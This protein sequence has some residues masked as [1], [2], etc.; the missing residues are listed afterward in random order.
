[1][2][3]RS[4]WN[5]GRRSHSFSRCSLPL[6]RQLSIALGESVLRSISSSLSRISMDPVPAKIILEA[7]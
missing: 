3:S 6:L 5:A 1:M 4:C 2:R 7:C